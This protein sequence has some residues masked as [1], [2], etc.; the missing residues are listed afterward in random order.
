MDALI[1]KIRGIVGETGI[2]LGEDAAARSDT[3]PPTGD[4][5]AKAIIRPSTTDEVSAVLKLCHQDGQSVVTHGGVTGLAGGALT[6]AD[7]IVISLER[8]RR[9]EPV[10]AIDR[11]LLV[12]AGAP[13]QL[14]LIHI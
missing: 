4:C 12:E 6:S 7:D 3:W 10:D 8:M 9:L 14:S 2:L 13:L 1:E 5:K 11:T